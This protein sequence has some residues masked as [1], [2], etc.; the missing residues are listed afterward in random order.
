MRLMH[1]MSGSSSM[2]LCACAMHTLQFMMSPHDMELG[3]LSEPL[4][5]ES[6]ESLIV[7]LLPCS[8]YDVVIIN[9]IIFS[10]AA[11]EPQ[12]HDESSTTD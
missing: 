12:D 8:E 1:Y 5:R 9:L 2:A 3:E 7:Q 11:G 10:I 4:H 6:T